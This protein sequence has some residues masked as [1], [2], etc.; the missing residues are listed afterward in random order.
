MPWAK[1]VFSLIAPLLVQGCKGLAHIEGSLHRR[2]RVGFEI[3]GHAENRFNFI[4][5]KLDHQAP[6]ESEWPAASG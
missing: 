4:A 5:R 2:I 3:D 6:D 1:T